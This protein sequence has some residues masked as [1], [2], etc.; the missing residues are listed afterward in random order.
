MRKQNDLKVI[1]GFTQAL[2]RGMRDPGQML[3]GAKTDVTVSEI[4]DHAEAEVCRNYSAITDRCLAYKAEMAKACV[5]MLE[6]VE[7]LEAA[8]KKAAGRLNDV[9]GKVS[10]SLAKTREIMGPNVEERLKQLERFCDVM[11]RLRVLNADGAI[12]RFSAALKAK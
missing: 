11:E 4:A 9:A 3:P 7:Q 6:E 10:Q 5:S 1:A 2:A 8:S 12:D